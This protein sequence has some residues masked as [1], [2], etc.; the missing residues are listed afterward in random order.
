MKRIERIYQ[1]AALLSLIA[2]VTACIHDDDFENL[3]PDTPP[4]SATSLTITVT[5]G[6]FSGKPETFNADADS[7]ATRAVESGYATEFT[8]GDRIGLY[9]EE[10]A[11][12]E[13]NVP[14]QVKRMLHTNLCLTYNGTT[15]TLPP[16]EKFTYTVPETDCDIRYFAYYPYQSEMTD[17]EPDGKCANRTTIASSAPE[18]FHQLI[19]NW[20]PLNDQSTY[21]AYTSSDL[22]VAQ[23]NMASRTDTNGFTLTFTMQHQ[24]ALAVIRLPHTVCTYTESIGGTDIA[25]NYDLYT[26]SSKGVFGCWFENHHT[27]RRLIKPS[28]ATSFPNNYYY[29]QDFKKHSFDLQFPNNAIGSGRYKLYTIDRATETTMERSLTAGDFYM[30]DGTIVSKEAFGGNTLP[31][32]VKKDCIG[33]VFWVGEK[34]NPVVNANYHWTMDGVKGDPLLKRDYPRCTHGMVVALTDASPDKKSWSSGKV[35]LYGWLYGFSP[36]DADEQRDRYLFLDTPSWYGYIHARCLEIYRNNTHYTT[37]AYDAV[38]EYAQT[39]ATPTDCSGWFFPGEYELSV[40]VFGT[41]D[42]K[43]DYGMPAILNAQF[44]KAGGDRFKEDE[45]Y[46]GSKNMSQDYVNC[47]SF[48]DNKKYAVEK[49]KLGYARA[50]L[51]F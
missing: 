6:A 34:W 8:T 11:V 10:V 23:G 4:T 51:A 30:K 27:A 37:E 18:F 44:D 22:M 39:I 43:E 41:I 3:I 24:M 9:V 17:N 32:D 36:F 50:V 33:V 35:E 13:F 16:G 7:P 38:E 46:W 48:K 25:K 42:Y 19:D 28:S 49:D 47:V 40:M 29:D 26:G 45:C 1:T 20:Q 21:A 14:T 5:D 12:N 15:W 2:L 31:D